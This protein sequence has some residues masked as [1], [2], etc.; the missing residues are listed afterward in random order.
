MN[1]LFLSLHHHPKRNVIG[2][3]D[4]F[5]RRIMLIQDLYQMSCVSQKHFLESVVSDGSILLSPFIVD[6]QELIVRKLV[7]FLL[8]NSTHSLNQT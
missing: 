3:D 1:K 5:K 7:G 2:I 8:F 4:Q 6:F